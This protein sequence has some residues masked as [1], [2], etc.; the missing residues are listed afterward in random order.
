[1]AKFALP[2]VFYFL[3]SQLLSIG[4]AA[5]SLYASH[6]SG[7]IYLLTLS[8]SGSLSITA[9]ITGGG[10][11]P[12]WLTYDGDTKSLYCSDE[13]MYG[14]GS[15]SSFSIGSDGRL[16]QTGKATAPYGGVANTLFG[17]S[18]GKSFIA[19]AH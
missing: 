5:E 8:D 7:Q 2:Y 14:S 19:I 1:M 17:G 6:Y 13:Q 9:S 15:I 4:Y 16:T 12:S 10:S 18:N 3:L 11:L